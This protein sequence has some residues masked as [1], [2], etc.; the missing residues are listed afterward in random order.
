MK[1]VIP[2]LLAIATSFL[3]QPAATVHAAEGTTATAEK[4]TIVHTNGLGTLLTGASKADGA[5]SKAVE[6]RLRDLRMK[7]ANSIFVDSGNLFGPDVI[8]DT[9]FGLPTYRMLDRL[10]Y[11]ASALGMRDAIY[12]RS[13]F[14][15]VPPESIIETPIVSPFH[16]LIEP[17]PSSNFR[18]ILPTHAE[19][20]FGAAKFQ[21]FGLSTTEGV[22]AFPEPLNQAK[23]LGDVSAQAQYVLDNIKDGYIPIILSDMTPFE[24]DSLARSLKRNALVIEGSFPWLEASIP[25]R[26]KRTRTIGPVQIVSHF[27]PGEADV[28]VLPKTLRCARAQTKAETFWDWSPGPPEKGI[29]S[30]VTG[31]S[32]EE[33]LVSS[34]FTDTVFLPLI[35]GKMGEPR[36]LDE[37]DLPYDRDAIQRTPPIQQ[38]DWQPPHWM[39][40]SRSLRDNEIV[41]RYSISYRND[42]IANVY[43]IRHWFAPRCLASLLIAV[44]EDH[45]LHKGRFVFPPMIAGR[46]LA[47]DNFFDRMQGKDLDEL[48]LEDFPERAGAEFYIDNVIRDIQLLLEWDKKY[49]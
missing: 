12:T 39:V 17:T 23:T 27:A 14:F 47:V 35:G 41:Y 16:H 22:K 11:S 49:D 18:K 8:S 29:F 2:G 43:R 45:H 20:T 42:H 21:F 4:I 33:R 6:E 5:T 19:T 3:L 37:I 44:D 36:L 9:Q 25:E 15:M 7:Y 1:R 40:E 24:N 28:I 31:K 32:L 10:D 34:W 48:K 13:L 26:K 46:P 30:W 38:P